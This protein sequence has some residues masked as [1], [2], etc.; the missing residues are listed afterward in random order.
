AQHR[1][2]L[3]LP[4][5]SMAWGPWAHEGGMLGRLDEVELRRMAR[6]GV[7]PLG[8]EEGLA[9][10]DAARAG[11]EPAVLPV[12][13]DL[14]ALR[15][16]AAASGIPQVLRGLVHAPARRTVDANA[17]AA[18]GVPLKQRLA[19]LAEAERRRLLVESVC[20]EVAAVLGHASAAEVDP[21]RAFKEIG[22]DSLTSV[23]LRNRLN[24]A[25]GLR[26]PATLVFDHPN[27]AALAD[28]LVAEL[29]DGAGAVAAPLPVL[30]E[31]DKLETLLLTTTTDGVERTKITLR[32]QSL[33][34]KWSD[35]H[36]A[37]DGS[38]AD[39]DADREL[40]S[41]TGDDIFDLL[42]KELGLS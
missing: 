35:A 38:A 14:P 31:L 29:V 3:G 27:P 32:L 5:T 42:D 33:L 1:A 19:G 40:E 22:F 9:L 13:L 23:E 36:S 8:A 39:R 26:L 21:D 12:R 16:R 6:S 7:P 34:S 17:A 15:A 28:H 25:T 2:A 4:A 24:T 20:A 18:G 37:T 11:V 10:F 41:A 30:S